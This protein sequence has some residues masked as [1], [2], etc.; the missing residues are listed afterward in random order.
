MK[1]KKY[2]RNGQD[3]FEVTF[4]SGE[5]EYF[6]DAHDAH[7]ADHLRRLLVLVLQYRRETRKLAQLPFPEGGSEECLDNL[8]ITN[9]PG[10][11]RHDKSD[12]R[13]GALRGPQLSTKP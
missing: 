3:L 2:N 10:K 1:Q 9:G 6:Q 4:I 12:G 11:P 13:E 8:Q 5:N 7:G